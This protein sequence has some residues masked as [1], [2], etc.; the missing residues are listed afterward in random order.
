MSH[1]TTATI[2]ITSD[3]LASLAEL[4]LRAG[5]LRHV[6]AESRR[7]AVGYALGRASP[8]ALA[9][10]GV[11]WANRRWWGRAEAGIDAAAD[12]AI[13]AAIAAEDAVGDRARVLALYA[14]SDPRVSEWADTAAS[15]VIGR[16]VRARHPVLA[17]GEGDLH[18]GDVPPL[19]E[20]GHRTSRYSLRAWIEAIPA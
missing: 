15:R 18:G 16:Q 17:E 3:A 4:A 8:A 14:S 19:D 12:A 9:D 5:G 10:L 7:D 1:A 2:T 6:G 11:R 13:A 20:D